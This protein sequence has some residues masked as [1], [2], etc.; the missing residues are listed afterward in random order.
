MQ[1]VA[2]SETGLGSDPYA[3]VEQSDFPRRSL[4]GDLIGVTGNGQ[5]VY[6][7]E[8][9]TELWGHHQQ[10]G[11]STTS[12]VVTRA[13]PQTGAHPEFDCTLCP[14]SGDTIQEASVTLD[15]GDEQLANYILEMAETQGKWNVLTARGW[16][17]L[18]NSEGNLSATQR[19]HSTS[20]TAEEGQ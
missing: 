16:E 9:T 17:V 6:V 8:A 4:A 5:G 15:G 18:A 19:S 3:W 10:E 20:A 14:P 2:D 13:V 1:L 12:Y 11:Q 7:Q